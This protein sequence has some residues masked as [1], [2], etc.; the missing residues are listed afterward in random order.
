MP[1]FRKE[2]DIERLIH[3]TKTAIACL[4]GIFLARFIGLRADQWVVVTIIVVMCGQIYVGSVLQKSMF[5][6][7]GTLVGCLFAICTL[8]SFGDSHPA[9][10]LSIALSS[11]IFSYVAT[12]NENLVNAGTLGAATTAIIMLGQQPTIHFAIERLLEISV[13]LLIASVISQFI[14]PI[15][16]RTHLRRTQA[17]TLEELRHYYVTCI[18]TQYADAESIQ[19]QDF[20]ETI[21]KLLSKQ[22][23]LIKESK[24]ELMG[25]YFDPKRGMQLLQCEKEILRAIDFMHNALINIGP[26]NPVLNQTN[27][28]RD[29]NNAI[30][31][32]LDN[33]VKALKTSSTPQI[34]LLNSFIELLEHE[35]EKNFHLITATDLVYFEGFLFSAKILASS[36]TSAT[37]L[38]SESFK[39]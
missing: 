27:S 19:Y 8:L 29:F 23:Q 31:Q 34:T 15:H 14:L 6:F 38:L 21:V 18:V 7:L 28:L 10:G 35:M 33:L 4:I 2:I 32:T 3:S 39:S 12:Q 24:R 25:E 26:N 1:L 16:A 37:R 17:R 13:G 22:R 36:L 9:V 20:D 30:T 5:R 11:F